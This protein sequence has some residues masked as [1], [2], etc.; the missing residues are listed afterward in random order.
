[1]MTSR[2]IGRQSEGRSQ[3]SPL[4]KDA[5]WHLN[6]MH[7]VGSVCVRQFISSYP[8]RKVDFFFL[9]YPYL[10]ANAIIWGFYYLCPVSEGQAPPSLSGRRWRL[11]RWRLVTVLTAG[12]VGRWVRQGSRHLYNAT[13]KRILYL[14]TVITITGH[15][16]CP[17]S[18]QIM[19]HR[20]FPDDI[21][22][23]VSQPPPEPTTCSLAVPAVIVV[24][25][26]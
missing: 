11:L 20:L 5:V 3:G 25:R 1:M 9:N 8:S 6:R 22:D 13:F 19:R 14:Q 17:A 4:V 16:I 15:H 10:L 2:Q 12:A 23:D 7:A 26:Y 21:G 24:D 18:V